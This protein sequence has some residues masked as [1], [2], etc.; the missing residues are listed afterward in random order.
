MLEIIIIS[1]SIIAFL[2]SAVTIIW[3]LTRKLISIEDLK[4]AEWKLVD[5]ECKLNE[6]RISLVSGSLT[7]TYTKC[8]DPISGEIR[9]RIY[10]S[11]KRAQGI[12]R[13][14]IK[15]DEILGACASNT[16]Y[17]PLSC[18]WAYDLKNEVEKAI[19]AHFKRQSPVGSS[20]SFP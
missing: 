18:Q 17:R 10:V 14:D 2:V 12:V 9:T 20:A 1:L 5:M 16:N 11:S 8:V 19:N 7:L 4:D 3:S 15:D 6:L 13:I